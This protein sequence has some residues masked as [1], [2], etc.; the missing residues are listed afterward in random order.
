[1]IGICWFRRLKKWSFIMNLSTA[2]K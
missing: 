1:M 2:I